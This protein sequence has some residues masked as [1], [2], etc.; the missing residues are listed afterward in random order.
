MDRGRG[1][2]NLELEN[3]DGWIGVGR[4]GCSRKSTGLAVRGSYIHLFIQKIGENIGNKCKDPEVGT[5]LSSS[6]SRLKA[7]A[8]V[9]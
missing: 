7:E 1:R 4:T 8:R 6:G 9:E 3:H 5:S 2:R